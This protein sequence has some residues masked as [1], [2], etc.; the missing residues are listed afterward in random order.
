MTF[1]KEL[2]SKDPENVVTKILKQ[3]NKL[4][5]LIV[6]YATRFIN[7]TLDTRFMLCTSEA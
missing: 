5:I 7:G 2:I 4:P 6:Y 3:I 1:F